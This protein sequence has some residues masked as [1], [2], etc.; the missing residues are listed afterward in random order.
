MK[1]FSTYRLNFSDFRQ[2]DWKK[3]EV[4][5]N[6]NKI[7]ALRFT[8]YDSTGMISFYLDNVY[9]EDMDIG[10]NSIL[11]PSPNG[12]ITT[13]KPVFS[14]G[15]LTYHNLQQ[16]S[17]SIKLSIF[18]V[19]GKLV[20]QRYLGATAG[21]GTVSLSGLPSGIYTL[22]HSLDGKTVGGR[23]KFTHTK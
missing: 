13:L 7:S 17:G 14:N 21:N 4:P 12:V 3:S 16:I 15:N 9:I 11:K 18:N 23:I 6:L 2:P 10:T 19:A 5:L 20:M 1:S 22:I 8:V